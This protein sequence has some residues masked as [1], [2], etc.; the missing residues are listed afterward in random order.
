MSLQ[1]NNSIFSM[2]NIKHAVSSAYHPQTNGQDERTNQNIK[3][4]LRK[5]VNQN[6]DDWDVH[7]AAVVYGIN[8]AK[9]HSTRHSPYFM[10]FHRHPRLPAVMNACP[11][12]DDFEV[13]NPEEDIDTRVE[14]MT[15]LNETVLRN[16]ER[17]QDTQKKTFGTRKR[18]QVIQKDDALEMHYRANTKD[19]PPTKR[20][21]LLDHSYGTPECQIDHQYASPGAKWQKDL[22]PLQSSL[23]EYVL[24]QNRPPGELLV[25]EDNICLTREDF[26]S[27]GLEHCLESNIGN[28]C[29]K[30]VGEAAQRHVICCT[31]I[32]FLRLKPSMGKDV[33][34]ADLY[35]VATWKDPQVNLLRC[36]PENFRSKDILLFP[37]WS[38]QACEADHYL[39]C[40]FPQQYNGNC[41]GI[42]ML[43]EDMPAI[44]QWW[45]IQLME[46]FCIEGLGQ[47]FA[48]WTEEASLLLQGTLQPV[49][50]VPKATSSKP[51]P[52]L[53]RQL[54]ACVLIDILEE[55][56]LH[57]GDTAICKLALVSSMFRDLVSTEYFR[58]RAHFKWLHSVC[59]WSSFS[60]KY[61]EQYFN[62]YTIEIC[63]QC[64][65]QYKH[66]PRGYVGTV[67]LQ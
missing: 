2:L 40:F 28:A 63:L 12:D 49:F 30:I 62:M 8:T 58:R 21:F 16:I 39:L 50:R 3:R 34:I 19:H 11:M 42:F 7:L 38:R 27:L 9:Q 13:A 44:R 51:L 46:R 36:L 20:K 26:W 15:V 43:M 1:L 22:D 66:C 23:L 35:V 64:G 60:E 47:R 31:G 53:I 33:H 24:D 61:R 56:V 48:F 32:F 10:L 17:A 6:H 45:C 5:Y 55:V 41:C 54:P 4:A 67:L 59:T 18:K 52:S 37:A 57:E 14:E 29:L 25:K 65:D